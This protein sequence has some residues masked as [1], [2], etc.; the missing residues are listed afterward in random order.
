M[1]ASES[2]LTSTAADLTTGFKEAGRTTSATHDPAT[3]LGVISAVAPGLASVILAVGAIVLGSLRSLWQTLALS[4][5]LAG[6]ARLDDGPARDLLDELCRV[7]PR[8]PQVRLLAAADDAEPAALG[9]W[10]WTIVL[11]RRAIADLSV[12]ELRSLLAH[13]LAH[14]AR[15]D[16]AW[17][18]ISRFVCSCL[19]F[20]PLNHL[21]RREWQ[22]AAEFLCDRW[23]VHRTGSPLALARC[24]TEVASWRLAAQSSA[25]SLAA[26]GRKSGLVDR[27]ERLLDARPLPE[28]GDDRRIFRQAACYGGIGLVLLAWC[29]PRVTVIAATTEFRQ[30]VEHGAPGNVEIAARSSEDDQ[31]ADAVTD[32]AKPQTSDEPELKVEESDSAS[33]LQSVS[34]QT[35]S[36]QTLS[37]LAPEKARQSF[38]NMLVMLDRDLA[39]LEVELA[40]I[41]PLLRNAAGAPAGCGIGV[42]VAQRNRPLEAAA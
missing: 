14:L 4:R 42:E 31:V 19:A 21:A 37:E 1:D 2:P 13:E 39:A 23:A 6:C 17:L 8:A 9:V 30:S 3:L 32:V 15:G 40:A 20:Q 18:C 29:A 38:P 33:E 5:K 12:D 11:P 27:I 10:R 36:E 7:V 26:T 16:A 22:R 41:E 25:A 34:E 24:L 28:A 35:L